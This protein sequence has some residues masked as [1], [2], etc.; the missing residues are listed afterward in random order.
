MGATEAQSKVNGS[1]STEIGTFTVTQVRE[2]NGS[3][4]FWTQFLDGRSEALHEY[5]PVDGTPLSHG[6]VRLHTEMAK[7][8]HCGAIANVTRVEV[9]GFRKTPLQSPGADNG[10]DK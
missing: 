2:S 10:M 3:I 8:I 6:C 5:F 4:N 9:R 1:N 7:K